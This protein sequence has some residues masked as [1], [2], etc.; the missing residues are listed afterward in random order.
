MTRSVHVRGGRGFTLM[1][2]LVVL[3]I[4]AALLALIVPR[5]LGTQKK[6]DI[7]ATQSQIKLL[8]GCLQRYALDMKEFPSTE[9]GL[10]ALVE[11]PADLSEAVTGRWDGPYT[12]TGELPEDPWGNPF[13]YEYPPTHGTVDYPDVWSWGPDGEDGTEDDIT[14]WSKERSE[15]G[16][17]AAPAKGTPRSGPAKSTPRS[18]PA[19][20]TPRPK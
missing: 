12:E 5:I 7:S 19:K 13:Q 11:K 2:M 16:R 15:E 4:L 1:E 14:S 6:A 18:G 17:Q 20:S 3:A 8:G 10:Q 9:Q